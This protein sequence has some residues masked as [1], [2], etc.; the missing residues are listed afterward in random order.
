MRLEVELRTLM[1][2][3]QVTVVNRGVNGEESREMLARFER[4]VFAAGAAR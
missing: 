1:P 4:D 2:R 3:L